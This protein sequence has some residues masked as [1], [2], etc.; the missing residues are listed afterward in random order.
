MT[1]LAVRALLA[2]AVVAR[3]GH[4]RQQLRALIHAFQLAHVA[5]QR[6]ARKL[7]DPVH[8]GLQFTQVHHRILARQFQPV[9]AEIAAAPLE[10][11]LAQRQAEQAGQIRQIT[12]VELVLQV[13]GRGRYQYAVTAEQCRNQVGKGLAD[14]G[15]RFHHQCLAACNRISHGTGHLQLAVTLAI[16]RIVACQRPIGRQHMGNLLSQLAMRRLDGIG[17]NRGTAHEAYCT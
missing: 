11:C 15:T 4:Q 13:L 12:R 2:Q 17:I 1:V 7:F 9:Q 6:T 16:G 10:Q 5:A 14:P 8:I 3:R